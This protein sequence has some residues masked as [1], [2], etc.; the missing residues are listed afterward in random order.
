MTKSKKNRINPRTNISRKAFMRKVAISS[1][2]MLEEYIPLNVYTPIRLPVPK[3][4]IT[5]EQWDADVMWCWLMSVKSIRMIH[6]A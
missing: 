5:K 4:K 3:E 6:L 2:Y 1:D